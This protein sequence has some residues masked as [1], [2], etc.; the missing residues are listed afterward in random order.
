MYI[1]CTVDQEIFPLEMIHVHV[2]KF[3][4]VKFSQFDIF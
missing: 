4:G 3:C 1:F 2:K